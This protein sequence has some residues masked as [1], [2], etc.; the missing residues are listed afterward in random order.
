MCPPKAKR[1]PNLTN[2]YWITNDGNA[3][4]VIA[5]AY[6]AK[7]IAN[8]PKCPSFYNDKTQDCLNCPQSYYYNY[9]TNA[10]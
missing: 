2:F 3:D 6:N 7:S 5:A 10:C 8:G 1:Y 9:D 4:K